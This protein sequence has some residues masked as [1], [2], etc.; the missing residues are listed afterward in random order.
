VTFLCE[1]LP[2]HHLVLVPPASE[3]Y[4]PLLSDIQRR[5]S[6]PIDGSPPLPEHLRPRIS[7]ED[8]PT[9]AILLNRSSKAIAALQVVWRFETQT[10]RSYRHSQGMLSPQGLLLRF[11]RSDDAQFKLYG[12]WHTI[13]PG[14]KRYLGESGMVGDNTDV[15]PPAAD[16]KWRGG[17]I[18]VTGRGGGNS[19]DPVRQVTLV[20]DGVFFL[21]GEFVGPNAERLFDQTVADAEAHLIV[22][23]IAREGHNKGQRPGEILAEIE[24]AT[25]PAPKRPPMDLAYRNPGASQEEFRRAALQTVAFQLAMRR[26]LPQASDEEQTVFMV[27][28]W[29]DT[30]LPHFRKGD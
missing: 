22:A 17:I 23:R 25:G 12:Y 29:N 26:R 5:L 6:D 19:R 21:D 8:R 28:A 15:R 1:D 16:E 13:L 3:G 2:K 14:S 30:V 9:S 18:G 24:R 20:L 10:G 27:M 4:D 7:P 11:G